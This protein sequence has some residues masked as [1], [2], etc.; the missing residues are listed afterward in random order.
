MLPEILQQLLVCPLDRGELEEYPE[1]QELVCRQCGRVYPVRNGIPVMLVESGSQEER[2][3]TDGT[4][5]L[6][7]T[8]G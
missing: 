2:K 7:N 6:R 3:K 8:R 1:R 5:L 4:E